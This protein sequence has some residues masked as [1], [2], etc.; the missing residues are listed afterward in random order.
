MDSSCSSEVEFECLPLFRV[1]KDGVVERLRGTE[2]VPP[3]DVPQNGVVSKDVVISPETGLSARLFLPMT[4]TPDRK[5]PILI[6][7]H[8]GGFVIESPFSPLYHP[9]VVSLASAANVIAVSVHYRRPPEHPIPIPHD[10]TWDA[11]QW[12]AAHSSGQGPEPW[13]NHHAKFDRVFFAGDSAGANIAH[14]MAMRTGTTQPPN[15]K[16]CGIVLVH[17]YFGNNGPDRL[18]N[19]LCPSGVHNLLF[20]PAVDTKLSIL[21]CGKVLIFVAGKDV[22]KDR[23]FCYYEAVKKS[24]WGGAVEILESEGEEH[25]FH[26]FNP[27]CD[28]ARALIQKFASFMNQD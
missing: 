16:I 5:L 24:G 17:P 21:G 13:L 6:Y 10:D 4:A 26:L 15:V 14:N 25:V 7:I 9:H 18:W 28:K 8:G 22:L 2:T 27:D 23:G 3:S 12:V 20:D 19:Y 11:F 1:F